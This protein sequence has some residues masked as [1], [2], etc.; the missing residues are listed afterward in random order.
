VTIRAEGREVRASTLWRHRHDKGV[1]RGVSWD[2]H[3]GRGAEA[4]GPRR[5]AVENRWILS[6]QRAEMFHPAGK[7]GSSVIEGLT[8]F[9][10]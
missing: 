10:L 1:S 2:F 7:Q 6:D 5:L 8:N 4:D 9:Q 3:A